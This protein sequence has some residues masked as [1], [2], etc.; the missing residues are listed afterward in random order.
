MF[1]SVF[2]TGIYA[3]Y[4]VSATPAFTSG[5][6]LVFNAKSSKTKQQVSLFKFDKKLFEQMVQE[7]SSHSFNAISKSTYKLI[8]AEAITYVKTYVAN[9]IRFKHPNI[10]SVIEPLEERQNSFIF[11]TEL[12]TTDLNNFMKDQANKENDNQLIV[13]N[14]LLQVCTALEFLHN[15]AN[16]I[17]LNLVPSSIFIT[18]KLDFKLS[19]FNFIQRYD[20]SNSTYNFV[21]PDERFPKFL[22]LTYDFTDPTL[23][24]DHQFSYAN[25]IFALG[26]LIYYL[27]NSKRGK[28][29]ISCQNDLFDYKSSVNKIK[30][31]NVSY[32]FDDDFLNANFNKLIDI[33]PHSRVRIEDFKNSS[34]FNNELLNSLDFL[35]NFNSKT[36]VEKNIF[37]KGFHQRNFFAKFPKF[38]L[39]DKFLP[40]LKETI[41]SISNLV[42]F[43]ITLTC[44]FKIADNL[45]NLS[46]VNLLLEVFKP[47]QIKSN[48][49]NV[50]LNII[51]FTEIQLII[52]EHLKS[53][54]QKIN[55]STAGNFKK[56][57]KS[58]LVPLINNVL[59]DGAISI[60][61]L[62]TEAN[63]N[64]IQNTF[65]SIKTLGQVSPEKLKIQERFLSNLS[66]IISTLQKQSGNG[67]SKFIETEIF[68]KVSQVFK[69]TTSLAIRIEVINN[70]IQ[71][72]KEKLVSTTFSSKK[73]IPLL[74]AIKLKNDQQILQ[75]L[76]DFYKLYLDDDDLFDKSLLVD[77]ILPEL[78]KLSFKTNELTIE[79]FNEFFDLITKFQVKLKERH[80]IYLNKYN[81]KNIIKNNSLQNKS[82]LDSPVNS[83]INNDQIATFESIVNGNKVA[84][85]NIDSNSIRQSNNSTPTVNALGSGESLF[86]SNVNALQSANSTPDISSTLAE[87][88]NSKPLSSQPAVLNEF[89]SIL[90]PSNKRT[91]SP[92]PMAASTLSSMRVLQPTH[93][94]TRPS[95]LSISQSNCN[96]PH[97]TSAT[98]NNNNNSSHSDKNIDWSSETSKMNRGKLTLSSNNVLKPANKRANRINLTGGSN[99]S[100]SSAFSSASPSLSP[101]S[102]NSNAVNSN[103]NSNSNLPPGFSMGL[104]QP[105]KPNFNQN[106]S[107]KQ[108]QSYNQNHNLTS[109]YAKA[110]DDFFDSLL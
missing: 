52:L 102:S 99:P 70:F 10:L 90:T 63:S 9:L 48:K 85:G 79:K 13:T 39:I 26:C 25:D 61:Q 104:I 45:S 47:L 77:T 72:T 46:F 58:F 69:Q 81:D 66:L 71:L 7:S 97:S 11:V 31:G 82:S 83:P 103:A 101:S 1:N 29:L 53:I 68:P 84:G 50:E 109:Q 73:I 65:N 23:L 108:N 16:T 59:A 55:T 93:E 88:I 105:N 15:N 33:N 95:A 35:N 42:I 24:L 12:V 27:L 110:S 22:S 34:F 20:P 106:V 18:E 32:K 86:L 60:E 76:Y 100:S 14:G 19:G 87:N 21:A 37:L 3:H 62:Q 17:H 91:P 51:S 67:S 40:T 56:V 98:S 57:E 74:I 107:Q 49:K 36:L 38:L 80:T 64:A 94:S 75:G 78:L 4:S 44:I 41:S 2:K 6:W 89:S 92:A 8:L 43:P 5:P 28:K 54:L 96:A 30:M